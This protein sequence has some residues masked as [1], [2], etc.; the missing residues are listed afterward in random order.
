MLVGELSTREETESERNQKKEK[1]EKRK[2]S[3]TTTQR[4]HYAENEPHTHT[5]NR[6]NTQE[7]ATTTETTA[8]TQRKRNYAKYTNDDKPPVQQQSTKQRD[9]ALT[10]TQ[11]K[12]SEPRPAAEFRSAPL[13]VISPSA[14]YSI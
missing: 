12:H 11:N 7:F 10:T 13:R 3:K 2:K 4:A 5:Y 1:R 14:R 6:S 9:N 8:H